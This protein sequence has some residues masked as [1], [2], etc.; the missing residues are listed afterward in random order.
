MNTTEVRCRPGTTAF[1]GGFGSYNCLTYGDT[2]NEE[3][4]TENA[5]YKHTGVSAFRSSHA[6]GGCVF[7]LGDG[8]VRFLRDSMELASYRALGSRAGGDVAAAID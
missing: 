8:S 3:S 4:N 7:V 5:W 6:G 1:S 2:F